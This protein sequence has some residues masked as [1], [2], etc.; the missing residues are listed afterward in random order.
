MWDSLPCTLEEVIQPAVL[1]AAKPKITIDPAQLEKI[2]MDA[3]LTRDSLLTEEELAEVSDEE[4]TLFSKEEPQPEPEKISPN[5]SA[6]DSV[7]PGLD[8]SYLH[9]LHVLLQG[10]S[11]EP[12]LQAHKWMPSVVADAINEA[13]FE[14]IG[15]SVLACDGETI[16]VVEEY[17]ED[18]LGLLG[19]ISG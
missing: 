1:E 10:G 14:E 2:R 9:L 18:I 3:L 5:V 15:D 7:L 8:G 4:N 6:A 16:H 19:G 17:R 12:I 11:P 13:F